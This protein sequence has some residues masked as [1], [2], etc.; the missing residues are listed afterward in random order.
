MILKNNT[1]K[2]RFYTVVV[3]GV[4]QRIWIGGYQ[5]YDLSKISKEFEDGEIRSSG[6][7]I[8]STKSSGDNDYVLV[9]SNGYSLVNNFKNRDKKMLKTDLEKII[10]TVPSVV[11]DPNQF[12]LVDF[13][14]SSFN[15]RLGTTNIEVFLLPGYGN[16]SEVFQV[17]GTLGL[18]V[19]GV[20]NKNFTSF[21]SGFNMDYVT[22]SVRFA[23]G[24]SDTVPEGVSN[25]SSSLKFTFVEA[26]RVPAP[27]GSYVIY[28]ADGAGKNGAFVLLDESYGNIV[29]T[30]SSELI[31]GFDIVDVYGNSVFAGEPSDITTQ[32]DGGILRTRLDFGM[33]TIPISDCYLLPIMS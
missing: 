27:N 29:A 11:V 1:P 17:Q 8:S 14:T 31:T 22:T 13:Y 24:Q 25:T 23:F 15:E 12:Y 2:G 3:E 4:P 26:A 10:K 20:F 30:L 5:E 18:Y 9:K 21:E 16:I 32:E 33:V 28:L 7:K 6:R 19:D